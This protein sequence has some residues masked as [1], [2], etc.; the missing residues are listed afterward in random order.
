MRGHYSS[1]Y[2]PSTNAYMLM[3]RQIDK[4][5]NAIAITVDTFPPHIKKLLKQMK[6][7]EEE[8]RL[9]K[10]KE[11][12][13]IKTKIYC[14]HPVQ[15]QLVDCTLMLAMDDELGAAAKECLQ[16]FELEESVAPEDARLVSYNKHLDMIIC[17][18]DNDLVRLCEVTA[19]F[20]VCHSDFLLEIKQPG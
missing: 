11:N 9:I 6:A 10:E 20:N 3:Y 2:S 4:E 16:R 14:Y 17:S 15:K 13:M 7:K 19:K 12:D 8:E 18:F 1:A 5:R